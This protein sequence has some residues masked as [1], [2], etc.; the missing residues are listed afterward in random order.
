VRKRTAAAPRTQVHLE[1]VRREANEP[2]APLPSLPSLSG[3]IRE[4]RAESRLTLTAVNQDLGV[5]VRELAALSGLQYQIDPEVRGTVNTA[6][7]NKTLPRRLR[8][9]SRK[10]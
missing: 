1:P 10:G 6:L 4:K 2:A 3:D 9:S 7:R 8:R 5:V